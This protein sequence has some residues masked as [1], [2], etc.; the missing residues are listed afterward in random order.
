MK[1]RFGVIDERFLRYIKGLYWSSVEDLVIVQT[2]NECRNS[3][4]IFTALLAVNLYAR[5]V[6]RSEKDRHYERSANIHGQL[7]CEGKKKRKKYAKK[8]MKRCIRNCKV[9]AVISRGFFRL[10]SSALLVAGA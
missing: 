7:T 1:A 3:R 9:R 2:F 4:G 6:R 5:R 8:G 10:Y